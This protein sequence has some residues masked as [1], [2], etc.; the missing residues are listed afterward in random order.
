MVTLIGP[1][2]DERYGFSKNLIDK[3]EYYMNINKEDEKYDR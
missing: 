1:L 3:F 2:T